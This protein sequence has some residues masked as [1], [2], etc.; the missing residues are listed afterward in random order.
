MAVCLKIIGGVTVLNSEFAVV[1]HPG[2]VLTYADEIV[3]D[4]IRGVEEALTYGD[5]HIRPADKATAVGS[6]SIRMQ[7]AR[8]RAALYDQRVTVG[9]GTYQS[10]I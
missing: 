9:S 10:A 7:I 5:G 4:Q 2:E 3:P 6:T 8:E 1:C